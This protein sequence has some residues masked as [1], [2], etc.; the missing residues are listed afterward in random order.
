[1]TVSADYQAY[2]LDQFAPFAKV[3]SR[4]MFG[5]IG[6]YADGLFF[7][8]IDD[9]TLYLKVDDSNRD[10]YVRRGSRAFCPYADDPTRSMNYF[11]LPEDVLED[12]DTLRSWVRNSLSVAAAQSMA[13][14]IR[15]KKSKTKQ[16]RR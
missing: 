3:V 4:R 12:S 16:S 7:G 5:A 13:K 1:M 11:Q 2:V 6:L 10:D 14:P 15:K 9:D 8:I